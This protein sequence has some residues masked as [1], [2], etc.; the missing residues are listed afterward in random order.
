MCYSNI[1]SEIDNNKGN[2]YSNVKGN[3]CSV[4]IK[5]V[6]TTIVIT[7][8]VITTIVISTIVISTM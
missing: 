4:K 5:I 6:I 2:G 7:T 3:G 8:K 1:I